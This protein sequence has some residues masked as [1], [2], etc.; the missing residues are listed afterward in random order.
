MS[1]PKCFICITTLSSPHHPIDL[2]G[3]ELPDEVSNS[4]TIDSK[5]VET[6]VKTELAVK[7]AKN[8]PLGANAIETIGAFGPDPPILPLQ[9]TSTKP[10]FGLVEGCISETTT[11]PSDV[12][13]N[14]SGRLD[15]AY[16]LGNTAIHP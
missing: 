4:N 2:G 8:L 6:T 3:D 7:H 1:T 15:G 11:D 9:S 10:L 13:K 16:S 5:V 12:A 14:N